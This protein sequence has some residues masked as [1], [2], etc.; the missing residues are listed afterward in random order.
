MKRL[1]AEAVLVNP[2]EADDVVRAYPS[3]PRPHKMNHFVRSELPV[4]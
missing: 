2:G 1:V 4:R 3:S